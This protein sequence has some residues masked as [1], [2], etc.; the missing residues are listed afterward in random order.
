MIARIAL[1]TAAFCLMLLVVS[2]EFLFVVVYSYLLGL[3][4]AAGIVAQRET[5]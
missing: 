1:W 3:L 4:A 2:P 5:A